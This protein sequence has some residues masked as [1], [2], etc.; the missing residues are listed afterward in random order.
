ML[1]GMGQRV[2][3][4]FEEAE[5][6]GGLMGKIRLASKALIASTE[7]AAVP[8]SPE[9]LERVEKAMQAIRAEFSGRGRARTEDGRGL[10]PQGREADGDTL[11]RHLEVLLE[12]MTQR[13]LF[14]GDVHTTSQRITES[15]ALVLGV[16][17]VSVWFA[18]EGLSKI[19]CADLFERTPA[20]HSAGTELA[21]A[22]FAPYFRALK[23]ERTIAAHD[24]LTD[25]R[26]SCFSEVYLRPLNIS[27]LLDVPIW[28]DRKMVG[29]VC[30]EQVGP[31]RGWTRDDERFAYFMGSF[32][33]LALERRR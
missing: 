9:L 20:R 10:I 13:S 21:A 29:V 2:V 19:V 24:A 4:S 14:V 11:R 17:R 31:G 1:A 33:A 26:T 28:F 32:V 6:L 16:E 30:H 8:D 3:Q 23:E 15:A 7:A 22:Q 25:P 27:A 18:D 5:R 12:L